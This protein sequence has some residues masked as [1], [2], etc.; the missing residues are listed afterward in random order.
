MKKLTIT[1]ASIG[2]AISFLCA[3]VALLSDK[4][5]SFKQMVFWLFLLLIYSNIY[6]GSKDV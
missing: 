2:M 1:G 6:F 4:P 3:W 5:D